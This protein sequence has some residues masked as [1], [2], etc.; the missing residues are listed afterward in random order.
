MN[1]L[2]R[3]CRSKHYRKSGS[4]CNVHD[5]ELNVD[6]PTEQMEEFHI[7]SLRSSVNLQDEIYTMVDV[8]GSKVTVKL[9]TGAK[10]KL[11]LR[12]VN[13]QTTKTVHHKYT[14]AC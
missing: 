6:P 10:C 14:Q 1:H 8:G 13:M 3:F 9:D 2:S 11:P 7:E 4:Q 12:I 5:V